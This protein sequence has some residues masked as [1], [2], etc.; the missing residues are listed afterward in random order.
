MEILVNCVLI[1]LNDNGLTNYLSVRVSHTKETSIHSPDVTLSGFRATDSIRGDSWNWLF[2]LSSI[3][4][5]IR[6]FSI[7]RTNLS[8]D[9]LS[10]DVT[11]FSFILDVS[12]KRK[13]DKIWLNPH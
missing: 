5:S 11:T 1:F 7:H 6:Y 13:S 9:S 4:R 10:L 2:V 12:D 3:V 8:I